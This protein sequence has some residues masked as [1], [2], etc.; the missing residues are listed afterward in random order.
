M[1]WIVK[2]ERNVEAAHSNGPVGQQCYTVHGHSWH[3]EVEYRYDEIDEYGWGP[4]FADVKKL[5]DALD[6][7]D[8]NKLFVRPSSEIISKWLYEQLQDELHVKVNW[9]S[10]SEGHGNTVRYYGDE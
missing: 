8:L 6:H 7:K 1:T 2:I 10:V 4:N 5:I 3:I 9:V